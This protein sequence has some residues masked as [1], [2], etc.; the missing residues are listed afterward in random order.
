M[1]APEAVRV[2]NYRRLCK[3]RYAAA[4]LLVPR[5]FKPSVRGPETSKKGISS[6]GLYCYISGTFVKF[7][8]F[9]KFPRLRRRGLSGNFGR[10]S[11]A[12]SVLLLALFAHAFL[13][14]A[15]HCHRFV[16][17]GAAGAH[18]EA[19]VGSREDSSRTAEF[20]GE[21]QCLLCRLQRNFVTDFDTVSLPV[22]AP[23]QEKQLR[24]LPPSLPPDSRAF[25]VPPGRA[26]PL[27]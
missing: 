14:S 12:A 22:G 25:Y 13:V 23:T 15:T 3:S 7:S 4:V 9:R 20:G 26:P 10:W 21:A 19:R 27:A 18:T 11:P 5:Q 1:P 8:Q 16:R 6:G 24:G 2:E 17:A